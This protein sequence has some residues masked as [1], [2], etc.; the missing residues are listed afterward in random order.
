LS[1]RSPGR[2]KKKEMLMME[3]CD[4][5]TSPGG[6]RPN[7]NAAEAQRPNSKGELACRVPREAEDTVKSDLDSCDPPF[8]RLIAAVCMSLRYGASL[9]KLGLPPPLPPSRDQEGG[10]DTAWPRLNPSDWRWSVS[11]MNDVRAGPPQVF[12]AVRC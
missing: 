9:E 6:S 10:S 12:D 8:S 7:Y 11:A 4:F 1:S 3:L 2:C 5:T